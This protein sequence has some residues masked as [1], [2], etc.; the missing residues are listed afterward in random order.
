MGSQDAGGHGGYGTRS[1]RGWKRTGNE[2]QRFPR[3]TGHKEVIP[4]SWE[5]KEPATQPRNKGQGSSSSRQGEERLPPQAKDISDAVYNTWSR[6]Y[7]ISWMARLSQAGKTMGTFV[8]KDGGNIT[9]GSST[10]VERG[11]VA[12]LC[13]QLKGLYWFKSPRKR[14]DRKDKK[15]RSGRRKRVWYLHVLLL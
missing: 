12:K 5:G 15:W 11:N 7:W 1:A 6:W 8:I 10:F 3:Q 13:L 4:W 9:W 2:T 14:N